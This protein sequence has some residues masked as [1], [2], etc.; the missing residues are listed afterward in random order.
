MSHSGP[1]GEHSKVLLAP[2]VDDSDEIEIL[3]PGKKYKRNHGVHS[4]CKSYHKIRA[5]KARRFARAFKQSL[6]LYI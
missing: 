4:V 1:Y 3:G 2:V 5:E 6:Y